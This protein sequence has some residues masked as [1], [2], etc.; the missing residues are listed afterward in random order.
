V[1]DIEFIVT[2]RIGFL[3]GAVGHT[4]LSLDGEILVKRSQ[5][6]TG[7]GSI[8]I[9][10]PFF[11]A[12]L[13]ARSKEQGSHGNHYGHYSDFHS[14]RIFVCKGK[15]ISANKRTFPHFISEFID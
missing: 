6:E 15:E 3:V 4:V 11:I 10:H 1:V 9:A 5:R 7:D 8:T 2:S 13:Q 14:D 12:R